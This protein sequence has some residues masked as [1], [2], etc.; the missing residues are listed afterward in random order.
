MAA[1]LRSVVGFSRTTLD[2]KKAQNRFFLLLRQ[3]KTQN[4]VSA[5]LSGVD[6]DETAKSKLLDDLVPLYKDAMAKKKSMIASE[7]A[8]KAGDTKIVRDQ[9]MS[10]GHRQSTS[11]SEQ[12]G[13]TSTGKRRMI[14][15]AQQLEIALKREKMAFKK[16]KFEREMEEKEKDRLEREK[17]RQERQQIRDIENR[18]NEEMMRIIRHFIEKS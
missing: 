15:D 7:A 5:R 8:L 9:A 10:R 11:D 12:G 2:G 16:V 17:E 13:P 3:N 1:T 18:L 4:D 6:E 14:L